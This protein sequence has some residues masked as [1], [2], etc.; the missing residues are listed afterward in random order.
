MAENL[1]HAR[2]TACADD[3]WATHHVQVRRQ[4]IP[5][6]LEKLQEAKDGSETA[7]DAP[8]TASKRAKTTP[9]AAQEGFTEAEDGL[10]AAYISSKDGSK[11][12]RRHYRK[13]VPQA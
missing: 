3:N 5:K 12:A 11:K 8:K 4:N 1:A 13:S 10:R 9:R 6:K 2:C 7:G